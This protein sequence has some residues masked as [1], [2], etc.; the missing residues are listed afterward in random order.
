MIKPKM[1]VIENIA[2]LHFTTHFG[3]LQTHCVR[4]QSHQSFHLCYTGINQ[5]IKYAVQ[6]KAI[7]PDYVE[8][9]LAGGKTIR[10]CYGEKLSHGQQ[11]HMYEFFKVD[12]N[13]EY[14]WVVSSKEIEDDRMIYINLDILSDGKAVERLRIGP[15]FGRSKVIS[16]KE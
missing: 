14:N 2:T 3:E 6:I 11:V 10:A 8:V 5:I 16:F 9:Y 15:Y 1:K 4:K 7:W 13:M 12:K